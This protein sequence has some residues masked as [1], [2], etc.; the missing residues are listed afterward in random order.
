MCSVHRV[1][2]TV[3]R[4]P[5]NGHRA[6]D[7]VQRTP[8]NG[9][10]ATHTVQ[11][12]PCNGHR[13]THTVQRTPCN[14]VHVDPPPSTTEPARVTGRAFMQRD[15]MRSGIP[16]RAGYHGQQCPSQ[17]SRQGRHWSPFSML[18]EAPRSRKCEGNSIVHISRLRHARI[19]ARTHAYTHA[20]TYTRT[21]AR[22]HA[23]THARKY[24]RTHARTYT[25]T[26]ARK[27]TRTHARA[28][29]RTHARTH[30]RTG[31][32]VVYPRAM[33]SLNAESRYLQT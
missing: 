5:C 16:C 3:Q 33:F 26:H 27:Y 29:T 24:T 20:R 8:C 7:T 32:L 13:A 21:H 31:Q 30:A 4:T 15:T 9:H 2:H 10:R 25:R 6:T 12:T 19:H 11:R 18:A 1:T 14:V 28:Y 17:C 22:I 23:R